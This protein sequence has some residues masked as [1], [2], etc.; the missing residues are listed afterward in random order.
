MQYPVPACTY[1]TAQGEPEVVAALLIIHKN[2]HVAATNQA[3]VNVRKPDRPEI[4]QEMSETAWSEFNFNWKKYKRT[5]R[6]EGKNALIR[7]ELQECCSKT[8]KTR[9]FAMKRED[10][11]TIEEED[12]LAAIKATCVER[13]TLT[14]HMVRFHKIA[15]HP[16]ENPQSYL[17]RLKAQAALFDFTIKTK[18]SDACTKTVDKTIQRRKLPQIEKQYILLFSA[19]EMPKK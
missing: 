14:V 18:C 5:A 12:L 2:V 7:S 1:V 9:L 17:S 8:V 3:N 4:V 16:G 15:E 19:V 11:N 10:L 13:V 6:I